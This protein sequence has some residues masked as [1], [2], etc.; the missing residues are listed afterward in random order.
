MSR[1]L[2]EALKHVVGLD[3][4]EFREFLAHSASG[5]VIEV[6]GS[7]RRGGRRASRS[8]A[9]EALRDA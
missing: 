4:L 3:A 5:P 9:M 8:T 2:G 7:W 1:L 6:S